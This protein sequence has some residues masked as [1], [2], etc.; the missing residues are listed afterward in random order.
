MKMLSRFPIFVAFVFL[1]ASPLSFADSIRWKGT[2]DGNWDTTTA[3]WTGDNTTFEQGDDATFA[4]DPSTSQKITIVPS[5]VEPHMVTLS[6]STIGYRFGT[7]NTGGIG[8]DC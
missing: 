2:V 1:V 6:G 7:T 8:G 5:T 4:D 3:N